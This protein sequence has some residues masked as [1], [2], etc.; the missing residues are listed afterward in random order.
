MYVL[1]TTAGKVPM[2]DGF[3]MPV[4]VMLRELVVTI[5][6]EVTVTMLLVVLRAEQAEELLE[7]QATDEMVNEVGLK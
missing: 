4:R 2:L 3:V 1:M 5:V 7:M 6:A